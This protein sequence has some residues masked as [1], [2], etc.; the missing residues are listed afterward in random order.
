MMEEF[1]LKIGIFKNNLLLN[2][3]NIS[4]INNLFDESKSRGKSEA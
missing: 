4:E 1:Q 2:W 3:K